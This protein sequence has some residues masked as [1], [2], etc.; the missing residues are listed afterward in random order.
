MITILWLS[1]Y[2][3][4][5]RYGTAVLLI[6]V[7]LL[8]IGSSGGYA[9]EYHKQDYLCAVAHCD[10]CHTMHNSQ[11]G[12]AIDADSQGGNLFLLND[13]APSDT[14]LS[15]HT[16]YGQLSS[17]GQTLTPGGDFYWTAHDVA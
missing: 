16:E 2:D 12:A 11:D 6:V 8:L 5:I 9:Q 15:C 1:R 7:L 17:D 3:R 14:C 4:R 10:G 13:A